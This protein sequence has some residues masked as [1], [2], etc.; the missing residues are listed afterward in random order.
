MPKSLITPC[1]SALKTALIV[2][3]MLSMSLVCADPLKVCSDPDNMPFSKSEGSD[4]GLYIELAEMVGKRLGTSVEYVW[5]LTHNQ[6]RAVRNTMDSCDAYF[7]LPATADYKVRG[8][9]RTHA[10]LDVGYAIVGPASFKLGALEDLKGKRVGVLH[11]SPPHVLLSSETGY[12]PRNYRTQED[13]FAALAAG[14]V[15]LAILWGPSAGFENKTTQNNRWKITP[16]AGQG[17]NGQIAVAVSKNKPELKEKIDQALTELQPEIKQLQ[18]K[19]GFPQ[20]APVMLDAKASWLTTTHQVAGGH[21]PAG[22]I[23]FTDKSALPTLSHAR[24]DA[25]DLRLNMVKVSD[26]NIEETKSM[27]NSRC[28]HCHGQNGA[29]PQQ[30][31]DLRKLKIRYADKWQEVAH[32]TITKGRPDMG[33]PTWGGTISDDDIKRIIGFLETI[34]K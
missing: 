15:E 25:V 2:A 23:K 18:Q 14:E 29:S 24:A 31:R 8:A 34:Q 1:R 33:M 5:W 13:I 12:E 21:A 9:E 19:Y 3:G 27:F 28:S 7:A 20:A 32:T 17:L 11:G 22:A 26:T 30:E 4:K 10:F 16:V 6:R